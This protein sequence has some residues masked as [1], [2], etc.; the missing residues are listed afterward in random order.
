MPAVIDPSDIAHTIQIAIAPVFMLAGIGSLL[1]V[2]VQR[3]G[4]VVD[5]A[6]VIEATVAELPAAEHD[7]AVAELR[8]LDRRMTLANWSVFLCTSSAC[9]ICLVIAALFIA[10]LSG[11]GYARSTAFAFII[12]MSLLIVGMILFLLEVRV[13]LLSV[14]VRVELLERPGRRSWRR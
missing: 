6:R 1:N 7:R 5:R 14:R 8:V 3:L 9:A 2:V 10:Q 13:A 11:L 12:A 4:R